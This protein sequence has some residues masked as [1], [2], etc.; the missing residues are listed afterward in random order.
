MFLK[1]KNHE[2][3]QRGMPQKIIISNENRPKKKY[4]NEALTKQ[5]MNKTEQL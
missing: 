4:T 5:I 2:P 3:N 1:N